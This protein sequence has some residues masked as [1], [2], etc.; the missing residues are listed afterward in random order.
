MMMIIVCS[1][2]PF[3]KLHILK[4]LSNLK[5]VEVEDVYKLILMIAMMTVIVC[6]TVMMVMMMMMMMMM[7]MVMMGTKVSH[8]CQIIVHPNNLP[9]Q[10]QIETERM[11]TVI[12]RITIIIKD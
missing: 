10:C 1:G 2:H 7:N 9:T 4:I 8:L 11:L 3:A 12:I 6:S 5:L